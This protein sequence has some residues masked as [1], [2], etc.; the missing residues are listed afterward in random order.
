MT[1][2]DAGRD[3]AIETAVGVGQAHGVGEAVGV[4]IREQKPLRS[5]RLVFV[6]GDPPCAPVSNAARAQKREPVGNIIDSMGTDIEA[7]DVPS[8]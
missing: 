5:I 3:R 8:V 1:L 4:L 6:E 2:Q 7:H